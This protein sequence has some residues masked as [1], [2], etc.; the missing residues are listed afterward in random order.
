MV[1][2]YNSIADTLENVDIL[3]S[4]QYL[5]IQIEN[6]EGYFHPISIDRL[7]GQI[8]PNGNEKCELYFSGRD[9]IILEESLEEMTPASNAI[10][11][12]IEL[13]K[14]YYELQISC[15]GSSH[16]WTDITF[17]NIFDKI[18]SGLIVTFDQWPSF[19]G[20]QNWDDI[21]GVESDKDI[22]YN[23]LGTTFFMTETILH[24]LMHSIAIPN[25][26]GTSPLLIPC[27]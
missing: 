9:F 13:E 10:T 22:P 24:E 6:E 20:K 17:L 1:D 3:Y 25:P 23:S 5:D 15:T 4:C 8:N 11:T 21:I 2:I 27:L 16:T 19:L 26:T 14:E 7:N 18:E 12:T